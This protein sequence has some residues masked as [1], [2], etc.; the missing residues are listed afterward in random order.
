[1]ILRVDVPTN[2]NGVHNPDTDENFSTIQAAIDDPDTHDGH[3]ITVDAGTYIENVDVDKRVTLIGGGAD[4][5][6]V[7]AADAGDHVFNVTVDRVNISGFAVVGATEYMGGIYLNNANRCNIS[8]NIASDNFYGICLH[9]S[10][11][12]TLT[13]STMSGNAYNFYVNGNSLSHC[14]Q[15]IDA[16]NTVDEKPIYYWV[17]QDNKQIPC[18]AGFVGIVNCTNITVKD[19]TLMNNALGLLFAYSE[20]S[21]IENVTISSN[22]AAGISVWHSNNNTL[23]NNTMSSNDKGILLYSSSNNTLHHNNLIDNAQNAYDTSTNQWDSGSEGNYYSDYSG[24][25]NNTDGIGDDPHLIPGGSSTDR[26]P[27]MQPWSDTPQK[28]DLNSDGIITPADAAI[29]LQIAASGAHDDAADV[30]GDGRVTSLD[31]LMI[32]QAA[33]GNIEDPITGCGDLDQSILRMYDEDGDGW[34][35]DTWA[36]YAGIDLYHGRITQSEYDQ[37]K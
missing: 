25:D 22:Y 27:L 5:V 32:L 31:A 1:V 10:S 36:I 3:T 12:N 19:S 2:G 7:R 16:S 37:V 29:A 14:T 4:V 6:T 11:D 9:F 13:N 17:D 28:G 20:N 8:D 35:D 30:S 34:I 23:Q 18:D 33:A 21:R 24:T 26:F 15:N